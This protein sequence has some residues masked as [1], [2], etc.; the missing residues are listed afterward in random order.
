METITNYSDLI[1]VDWELGSMLDTYCNHSELKL[2]RTTRSNTVP[3]LELR[4]EHGHIVADGLG[5]LTYFQPIF[6]NHEVSMSHTLK[7]LV[8][9]LRPFVC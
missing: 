6:E 8:E 2:V 9:T 1:K 4:N 3:H 7:S 5:V